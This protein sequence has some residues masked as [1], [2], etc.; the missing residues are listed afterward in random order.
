M[1][2]NVPGPADPTAEAARRASEE[3]LAFLLELNDALRSLSDPQAV[4]EVASRLLGEHVHASRVQ[5]G[6]VDHDE[7]IVRHSYTNGVLP[8]VGRGPVSHFGAAVVEAF[9]RGEQIVV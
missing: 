8:F 7:Y 9:R 4:L 5:Y 2:P 3:R 1:S 6:D